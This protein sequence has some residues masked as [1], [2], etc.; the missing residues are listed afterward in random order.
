MDM[1][2]VKVWWEHPVNLTQLREE[3]R[4]VAGLDEAPPMSQNEVEHWVSCEADIA[5]EVLETALIVHSPDPLYSVPE[6]RRAAFEQARRFIDKG[7][8]QP[9]K[10]MLDD[11]IRQHAEKLVSEHAELL[12]RYRRSS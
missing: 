6:E 7:G 2:E 12:A 11:M 1:V 4:E 3:V 8:E 5:P 9:Y 10:A